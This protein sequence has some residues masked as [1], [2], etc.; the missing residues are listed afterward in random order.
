MRRDGTKSPLLLFCVSVELIDGTENS[1]T[2]DLEMPN[3]ADFS[4]WHD[5][6]ITAAPIKELS[7]FPWP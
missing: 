5:C 3:R 7:R 1:S 2:D 4:V 6:G